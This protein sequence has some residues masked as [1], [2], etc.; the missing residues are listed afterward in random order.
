VKTRHSAEFKRETARL[1]IMDGLSASEMS[2]R[3]DLNTVLGC[4]CRA[5]PNRCRQTV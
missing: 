4:P 2:E 1:M 5:Y 3:L